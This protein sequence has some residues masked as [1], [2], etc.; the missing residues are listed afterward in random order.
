ML[1]AIFAV[2]IL[3]ILGA[4][5]G[6]FIVSGIWRLANPDAINE[7]TAIGGMWGL[8]LGSPLGGTC[9]LIIG[10]ILAVRWGRG[11]TSSR[12]AA[13]PASASEPPGE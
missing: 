13:E 12:A 1:K 2:S 3:T 4:V 5:F 7:T 8:M 11:G 9:G 6:M 10:I